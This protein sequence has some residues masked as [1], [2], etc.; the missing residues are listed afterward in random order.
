MYSLNPTII[1]YNGSFYLLVRRE[2]DIQKWDKSIMSYELHKVNKNFQTLS[3]EDCIFQYNNHFYSKV[4]R[5]KWKEN[6]IVF[7]D[8]KFAFLKNKKIY[9]I[10]NLLFSQKIP[11]IFRVGIIEIN[12]KTKILKLHKVLLT[13]NMSNTEKNWVLYSFQG[14]YYVITHLIPYLVIYELTNHFEL[15]PK[16]RKYIYNINSFLTLKLHPDYKTL[17]LSP[18]QSPIQI[19]PNYLLFFTKKKLENCFYQY[20]ISMINLTNYKLRTIPFLIEEGYKKYLNSVHIINGKIVGCYGIADKD[21]EV[22]EIVLPE[23]VK[24]SILP[25]FSNYSIKL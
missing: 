24:K 13:K 23:S 19:H 17:F 20:Y 5:T 1:P 7:E 9:G 12:I 15:I 4:S 6:E 14:K 2:T 16:V 10:S 21:Y 22:K 25:F 18:C 3:K 8:I 11:R